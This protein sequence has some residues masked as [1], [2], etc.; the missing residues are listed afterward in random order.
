MGRP[1]HTQNSAFATPSP[2]SS[3]QPA[4]TT[5]STIVL[6]TA[7]ASSFT[8]MARTIVNT[9]LFLPEPFRLTAYNWE[10]YKIAIHALC[11]AN[12]LQ[13]HLVKHTYEGRFCLG[14]QQDEDAR[15]KWNEDDQLCKALI[16][17]NIQPDMLA[18]ACDIREA[19]HSRD[20]PAAF[21]WD[22]VVRY[23]NHYP[24]CKKR[25]EIC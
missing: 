23:E 25:K 8:T 15:R 2:A 20:R 6:H 9:Q 13:E 19:Y 22:L 17:L 18:R 14:A 12:E 10:V 3:F 7:P 1:A 24:T 21:L 5:A 11:F 4:A 16:V